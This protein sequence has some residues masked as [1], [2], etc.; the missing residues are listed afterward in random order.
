MLDSGPFVQVAR[1]HGVHV[2]PGS[3]ARAGR[4]PDPH[5]RICVDRPWPLVDAG[6]SRAGASPGAMRSAT[7]DRCSAEIGGSQP[8]DDPFRRSPEAGRDLPAPRI[9]CWTEQLAALSVVW[10]RCSCAWPWLATKY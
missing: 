6:L 10:P 1:R 2:A 8:D 7:K 4:K 3:V 9:P 5:I